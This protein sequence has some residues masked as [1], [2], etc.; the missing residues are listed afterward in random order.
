MTKMQNKYHSCNPKC[1]LF[2]I[3]LKALFGFILLSFRKP[4]MV[5]EALNPI[6]D[7]PELTGWNGNV[8]VALLLATLVEEITYRASCMIPGS[9]WVNG[10][11]PAVV[12]AWGCAADTSMC[13]NAT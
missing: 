10:C 11:L 5:L 12:G 9:Q 8:T 7:V 13:Q 1:Y 2:F 4:S 3:L 6:S